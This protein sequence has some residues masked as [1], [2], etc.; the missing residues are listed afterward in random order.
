M[1]KSL[2]L[3][4]LGL[5]SLGEANA[6]LAL[7]NFNSGLPGTWSMIKADAN[8]PSTSLNTVIITSLTTNAWMTRLRATGDSCMLTASLF[9]PAGTANRWL[10]SPSFTV[11]NNTT[12]LSWEDVEGITGGNDSMEVW[13][14]PTAGNTVPA[15][16]DMIYQDAAG[17]YVVDDVTGALTFVQHGVSLA[18]YAGQTITVAFRNHSTN[19]GTLRMDNVQTQNLANAT[20]GAVTAVTFPKI[21]AASSSTS[22]KATIKNN[23]SQ[24]ITAL[25]LTYTID[26]GTPVSQTFSGLN[27]YPF[28]TYTATFTTQVSN[29][30]VANHA[31]AIDIVQVNGAADPVTGNNQATGNF[32][33]A[34]QI[35]PR[36]GLIEEFSSSTCAPCA[37]FNAIFDPLA[38]NN[39]ANVPSSNFNVIKYQM[40]WPSPNNDRSFNAHGNT[41]RGYYGVSG[42]PDHYTNGMTGGAGNQA[43]ITASKSPSA[44]ID[45]TGS[46]VIHSNNTFDVSYSVTPYFTMSGNYSVHAAVV[47]RSFDLALNDPSQTTSQS[48]FVYAMREM[49]PNGNGT[50]VTTFTE[51]TPVTGNWAAHTYAVGNVQQNNYQWWSS[52]IAGDLVVFV[53]DNATGEVMQSKSIPASWP[54]S[55]PNIANDTKVLVYPNPAT[56]VAVVSLNMEY[57]AEVNISMTDAVGR[58]VYSSAQNLTGG[59]HDVTVNTTSFAPGI[60]NVTIKTEKGSLTE[61]LSVVK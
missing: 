11:P 27:I 52:P 1:K 49:F 38:V 39:N 17:P 2:L 8:T 61:R 35:V 40:N 57:A 46:F 22:V 55:T 7:E 51:G 20:D 18:A 25:Q 56:D 12:V 45:I 28:G 5:L 24:N 4:A 41:R 30:S 54:V 44:F 6:Q 26:G 43:E 13:V 60:Y 3:A 10:V 29:P 14:S 36:N 19:Q 48:H 9:T 42:I 32:T 37:S 16:T 31:I 23:G 33:V 34:T 15:F 47:Q 53:Q 58:V 50:A 21:V 59:R